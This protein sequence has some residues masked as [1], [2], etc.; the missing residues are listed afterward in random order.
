MSRLASS[1]TTLLSTLTTWQE[2]LVSFCSK[3]QKVSESPT[4]MDFQTLNNFLVCK[5]VLFAD[6]VF[7]KT[8]SEI[9]LFRFQ[10]LLGNAWNLDTFVWLQGTSFV[11]KLKTANVLNP[12]FLDFEQLGRLQ[13]QTL[14][15]SDS[16][17]KPDGW[18]DWNLDATCF[19]TR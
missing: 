4:S 13:F 6:S 2:K 9:H 16:V 5:K 19:I 10:S 11:W 1:S 15:I 14:Q 3:L 17:W 8:L 18:S 7:G 12:D